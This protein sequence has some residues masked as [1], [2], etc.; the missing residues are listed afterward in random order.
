MAVNLFASPS[1]P[2]EVSDPV[3]ARILAVSEDRIAGFVDEPFAAIATAAKLTEDVVIERLRAMLSASR[4]AGS[5]GI[6][7]PPSASWSREGSTFHSRAMNASR[8]LLASK[9]A[10]R[11]VGA[12]EG[13]VVEPPEAGP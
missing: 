5:P 6:E 2:T 11:I 10:R 7:I 4:W 9:A 13:V 12:L 3:N 8:R 1:I